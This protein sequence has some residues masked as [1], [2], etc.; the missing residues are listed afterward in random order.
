MIIERQ[1]SSDLAVNES[2]SYF[3]F[4]TGYSPAFQGALAEHLKVIRTL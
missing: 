2:A 4:F 1:S 3:Y